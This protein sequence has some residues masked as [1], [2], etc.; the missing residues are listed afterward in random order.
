MSPVV[1]DLIENTGLLRPPSHFTVGGW[2]YPENC[3][4]SVPQCWGNCV[5]TLAAR[6]G[7]HR[8]PTTSSLMTSYP[9]LPMKM[10]EPQKYKDRGPSQRS[11]EWRRI[12]CRFLRRP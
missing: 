2:L 9:S 5:S 10:P 8:R 12:E 1:S 6:P 4:D 3:G 11:Q 7:L